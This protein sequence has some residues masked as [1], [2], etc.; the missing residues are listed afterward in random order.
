MIKKIHNS[1]VPPEIKE[2]LIKFREDSQFVD[3]HHDELVQKY[4]DQWPAV[5]NNQV[6]AVNDDFEALLEELRTKG[7]SPGET[8]IELMST[9]KVTWIL[10]G[11]SK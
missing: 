5:Y 8:V 6:D 1:T 7:I 2:R 3:Q 11:R 4:P 9:E 10:A